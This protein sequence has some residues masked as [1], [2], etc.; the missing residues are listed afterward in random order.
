MLC[1]GVLYAWSILKVPF[2][3]A[4][5]WSRTGLALNFTI[6]MCCFCV[7]G[8]VSGTLISRYS[9]RKT[10]ILA[11]V[12]AATGLG[13]TSRLSGQIWMLYLTYG[14]IGGLGIGIMYNAVIS[15][16]NAWY[17][18][19]KG[20]V[21]GLLMMNYSISSMIFGKLA[22][23]LM[24]E[25][26]LSWRACYLLMGI[27]VG[28]MFLLAGLCL[29]NPS[30]EDTIGAVVKSGEKDAAL[31]QGEHTVSMLLK[32]PVFWSFF[33]FT[34]TLSSVCTAVISF[35]N[36][37]ALSLG[38]DTALAATLAGALSICNGLGRIISGK[39]ID[40]LGHWKTMLIANILSAIA[41]LLAI[42]S[43][44]LHS[45]FIGVLV[46]CMIGFSGGFSPTLT[47]AFVGAAFGRE[48]FAINF[49]VSNLA[50]VPA[51]FMATVVAFLMREDSYLGSFALLFGCA[52]VSFVM[53]RILK[54]LL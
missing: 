54:R 9:P 27:F 14:C 34:I 50:I 3:K 7:G 4:F 44:F 15:V 20:L 32:S 1:G 49:G 33:L 24:V 47:P 6:M 26:R 40:L 8:L 17:P 23:I 18:D 48:H 29:R 35:A 12:L 38:A 31:F 36:D 53:N 43:I 11:A 46:L 41:P 39:V 28:G 22:S 30:E 5:G 52:V 42:V 37:Y 25:N 51:S 16:V 21:T 19:K 10:L 45:L 2:E 13:L